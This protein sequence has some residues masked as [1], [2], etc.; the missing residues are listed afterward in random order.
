MSIMKDCSSDSTS[1]IRFDPRYR[2]TFVI[3]DKLPKE[4]DDVCVLFPALST[5]SPGPTTPKIV[6]GAMQSIFDF[7]L[8]TKHFSRFVSNFHADDPIL[9]NICVI[10]QWPRDFEGT[11]CPIE[12]AIYKFQ[13]DFEVKILYNGH[14]GVSTSSKELSG[15]NLSSLYYSMALALPAIY[16][17]M[18]V[19]AVDVTSEMMYCVPFAEYSDYLQDFVGM[20]TC[21]KKTMCPIDDEDPSR[22]YV[23]VREWLPY[24]S[25]MDYLL[26]SRLTADLYVRTMVFYSAS[27]C[28]VD[29]ALKDGAGTSTMAEQA[30][31]Q[32]RMASESLRIKATQ[33]LFQMSLEAELLHFVQSIHL[34]R[35]GR[36][37]G[38][39]E[40]DMI[41]TQPLKRG[42]K[43]FVTLQRSLLQAL[44]RD[45]QDCDLELV[46]GMFKS[47]PVL[48]VIENICHVVFV[49]FV[50]VGL[51]PVKAY[52]VAPPEIMSNLQMAKAAWM[53]EQPPA[54]WIDARSSLCAILVL[55]DLT[56][57][58]VLHGIEEEANLSVERSMRPNVYD[59]GSVRD[60]YHATLK[61]HP[62]CP[63]V[64]KRRPSDC[65]DIDRYQSSSK[66][67][68]ALAQVAHQSDDRTVATEG[69]VPVGT[70]S[71]SP[72]VEPS[73]CTPVQG[74]TRLPS[75]GCEI[76][77]IPK[78][79][80]AGSFTRHF[81]SKAHKEKEDAA[82]HGVQSEARSAPSEQE[83]VQ[84]E[85]EITEADDDPPPEPPTYTG[86]SDEQVRIVRRTH[87]SYGP[88]A[89]R[90]SDK[91]S[92]GFPFNLTHDAFILLSSKDRTIT[93]MADALKRN[94]TSVSTRIK[95]LKEMMKVETLGPESL[96][97]L[98]NLV[99]AR[100]SYKELS[101]QEALRCLQHAAI[102]A[103]VRADA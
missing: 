16:V 42:E 2:M 13:T 73:S 66:A 69:E 20:H 38:P 33:K 26:G 60:S 43:V 94:R 7:I 35:V 50:A 74:A 24:E 29:T 85:Q 70:R 41:L 25:S 90:D 92:N 77:K 52:S 54:A 61:L 103:H 98:R 18:R 8:Q 76:C 31:V 79:G 82:L 59:Y 87:T 32:S 53:H 10:A 47:K 14:C 22:S 27:A 17:P 44:I 63:N 3:E 83:E 51:C 75:D 9:G 99:T 78:F 23:I 48:Q 81:A 57:S 88:W 19:R 62:S 1:V 80:N 68:D 36:M 84:E 12:H 11:Q 86:Y 95:M 56:S 65:N 101:D 45:S 89:C 96:E 6:S 46:F 37:L 97:D 21:F 5:T 49:Q 93:E 64:D 15:L 72:G 28:C 4:G 40:S 39:F 30:I 71:S 34:D 100:T 58:I 102:K 91:T 67:M 55:F